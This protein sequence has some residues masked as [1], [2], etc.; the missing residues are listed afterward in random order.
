MKDRTLWQMAW[1]AAHALGAA[2]L[3]ALAAMLFLSLPVRAQAPQMDGVEPCLATHFDP[4][5]YLADLGA[6]GW[7]PI[8]PETR[9]AALSWLSDAFLPLSE[10]GFDYAGAG[11]PAPRRAEQLQRWDDM[12]AGMTEDNPPTTCSTPRRLHAG[13]AQRRFYLECSST[14]NTRIGPEPRSTRPGATCSTFFAGTQRGIL[15]DADPNAV[16][17]LRKGDSEAQ[18]PSWARTDW[19]PQPADDWTNALTGEWP[20]AQAEVKEAG[21]KIKAK[22]EKRASKSRI[23]SASAPCSIRSAR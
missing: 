5:R 21:K 19:P 10:E 13:L 3:V 22:A 17:R 1:R 15:G 9:G 7:Q 23:P 11:D 8:A 2:G 18:G 12:T 14:R 4:A 6:L 20:A 16:G